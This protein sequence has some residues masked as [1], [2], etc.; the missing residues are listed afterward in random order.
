MMR[1][2]L[3]SA[4]ATCL[5]APAFAG[6]AELEDTCKTP[7][8][9][10]HISLP[11][12]VENPP[13]LMFLHGAGGSG[14]MAIG[15]KAALERGYALIGPNGIKRPGSRFGSSWSFHPEREEIRDEEA[16]LR[17]VIADAAQKHGV[18]PDRILI[19]GFSIGGSMTSYLAC[20]HPDIAS[21]F[22]PVGGSF[23]RPHPALDACAAPVRLLH[24]HGWR[25]M[26]VPLEGRVLG[27]GTIAQGDVFYAM[28][29]WR[30]TNGCNNYRATEFASDDRFWRRG[31]DNC[32]AGALELIL[33]PGAHGVPKGWSDIAIDWFE[34]LDAEGG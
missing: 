15:M 10:Y 18:D 32:E 9:E 30:E 6:C 3:S 4:L 26:T 11:Q 17:Q 21:A 24:T 29:V 23:W 5:A 8:G 31:W 19:A 34:G 22:A 27:N 1:A 28:Q 20:D 33:H 2:I 14:K 13:V 12:G 25:D 16:F 7:L